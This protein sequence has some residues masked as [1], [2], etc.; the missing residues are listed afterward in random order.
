MLY[1]IS[2]FPVCHTQR[3]RMSHLYYKDVHVSQRCENI[4]IIT[5]FGPLLDDGLK[6]GTPKYL[7]GLP[8]SLLYVCLSVNKVHVTV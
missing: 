6:R 4:I 3:Y 7:K 2:L 1:G 5:L 8:L